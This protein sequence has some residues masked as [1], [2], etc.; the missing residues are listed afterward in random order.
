MEICLLTEL[1]S[2]KGENVFDANGYKHCTIRS[3]FGASDLLS[4]YWKEKKTF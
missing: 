1:R 2:L 3:P 4:A